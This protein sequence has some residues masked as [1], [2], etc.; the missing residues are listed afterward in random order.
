MVG[1]MS[2]IY[3]YLNALFRYYTVSTSGLYFCDQNRSFNS[4]ASVELCTVN[5]INKAVRE[6]YHVASFPHRHG[7][8]E[9]E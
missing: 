6:S 8:N 5:R 9:N 7:D 4:P 2:V 3:A 1:L